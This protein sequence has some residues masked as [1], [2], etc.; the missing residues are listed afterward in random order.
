VNEIFSPSRGIYQLQGGN[1]R[2]D[3]L[4]PRPNYKFPDECLTRKINKV[5]A[6]FEIFRSV[7]LSLMKNKLPD[8]K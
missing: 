3:K 1:G 7:V 5:L 6:R 2:T 8:K 4:I